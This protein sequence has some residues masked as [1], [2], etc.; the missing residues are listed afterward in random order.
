MTNEKFTRPLMHRIV[1][2]S[3]TGRRD[4][5]S[6]FEHPGA[7]Y[8]PDGAIRDSGN[9]EAARRRQAFVARIRLPRLEEPEETHKRR[10]R[11]YNN[12]HYFHVSVLQMIRDPLK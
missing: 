6:L 4:C 1:I 11:E 3:T 10:P 9:R 7:I 8:R 5:G 12:T 2:T